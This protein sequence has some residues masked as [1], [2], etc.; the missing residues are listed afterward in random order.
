[1]LGYLRMHHRFNTFFFNGIKIGILDQFLADLSHNLTLEILLEHTLG[2]F[3]AA[4]PFQFDLFVDLGKGL[5]ESR[6]H[7]FLGEG[8]SQFSCQDREIFDD[9]FH[10]QRFLLFSFLRLLP[11]QH[12]LFLA[13]SPYPACALCLISQGML[14]REGGLEPPRVTPLDPKSS[15]STNFTTLA[16]CKINYLHRINLFLA[17]PCS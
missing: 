6:P 15:A 11:R 12:C 3:A 14:V 1:M 17:W 13:R 5:V 9:D 8:D 2:N 10:G 4:K 16:Y 7:C